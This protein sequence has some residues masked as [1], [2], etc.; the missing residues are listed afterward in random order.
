MLK[1]SSPD[2]KTILGLAVPAILTQI[3]LTMVEVV[4]TIFIGRLGPVPL[5]ASALI[6]LIIWNVRMFGEGFAVGLTACMA[7][8]VG[9]GGNRGAALYFRT[10]VITFFFLAVILVP[11]FRFTHTGLFR[12]VRMPANLFG[13]S[14]A[15]FTLF[16]YFIPFVYVLTMLQFGFRA[17]GDT[18]TPMLV[19]VVMNVINIVLDWVLIFG[20]LGFPAMGIRGAAV[21]SV[22]S[23]VIGCIILLAASARKPWG[24]FAGGVFNGGRIF[25]F[26][27]L[28]RII[29]LGVPATLERLGMAVSQLVVMATAV[30]PLG[31]S[32]VAA[33][34]IVLRLASL[35]F[36]PGF[37]FSIAATTMAGQSLGAGDPDRASRLV[38]KSVGYA[39]IIFAAVAVLYFTVPGG[40]IR[41]FTDAKE[42]I[43]VS[44][45]PLRIYAALAIFLAPT[46]VLGGG[47]RGA[48]ETRFPMFAMIGSRFIIRLPLCWAL[49]IPAGLGLTGVW[50][51]MC[52]DFISR[53]IVFSIKFKRGR[54]KTIKI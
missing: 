33:F 41:L 9:A 27:Y 14:E 4:D 13:D 49:S 10:A 34:Q 21:G 28:W 23:F 12:A 54:W 48:G 1:T 38:W 16:V 7:R 18:R 52:L 42:I 50:I 44:K 6:M 3:S 5:A 47:L 45:Q 2:S 24:P 15:Y 19:G 20:K 31:S 37:G 17:A 26:P 29:K 35:S 32:A 40:L 30:N 36:M 25:S 11:V 51:G 22:T 46:M 53:S 39:G 43:S 8:K